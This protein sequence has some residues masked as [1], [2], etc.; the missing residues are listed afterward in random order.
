MD[1]TSLVYKKP[2]SKQ[3]YMI[4]FIEFSQLFDSAKGEPE[5]EIYFKGL[6]TTYMIIKYEDHVSFQ[7]CGVDDGSGEYDY[8]S[9]SVL[10]QTASV[11]DICLKDKWSDIE[12][13]IADSRY[14]LSLTD[15]LAAF[16]LQDC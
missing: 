6:E 2:E 13:I 1:F 15:E 7:R 4:S 12:T 10:Y 5:F 14:D 9:L 11:D 3:G 8:P 16:S